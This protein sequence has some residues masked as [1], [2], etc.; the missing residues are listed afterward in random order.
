MGV[1][2]PDQPIF[3]GEDFDMPAWINGVEVEPL[4]PVST[5]P[6]SVLEQATAPPPS[7]ATLPLP[8]PET[9]PITVCPTLT[10][11]DLVMIAC[12]TFGLARSDILVSAIL[13]GFT[14][15]LSREEIAECL[16]LLWLMGGESATQV[17]DVILLGQA[18]REPAGMVLAELLEWAAPYTER[19]S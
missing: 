8:S 13:I 3:F 12:S 7:Q 18:R 14:T 10:P 17:R 6:D 16:Q 2:A 5:G 15:S 9:Y 11:R 4:S 1:P 19:L